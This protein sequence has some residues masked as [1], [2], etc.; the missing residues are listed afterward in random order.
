MNLSIFVIVPLQS[1]F[2][3]KL[4]LAICTVGIVAFGICSFVFDWISVAANA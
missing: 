2:S 1:A 4:A 3:T